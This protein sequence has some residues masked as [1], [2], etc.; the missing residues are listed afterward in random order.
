MKFLSFIIFALTFFI[1]SCKKENNSVVDK[2]CETDSVTD[3]RE[4]SYHYSYNGNKISQVNTFDHG[5]PYHKITYS[6]SDSQLIEKAYFFIPSQQTTRKYSY[7]YENG[8]LSSI[9]EYKL[10]N[11]TSIF[12]KK[13]VS[14]FIYN[15]KSLSV[16]RTLFF[17]TDTINAN[18][19]IE[20]YFFGS[21]NTDSAVLNDLSNVS[22][23]YGMD[24]KNNPLKKDYFFL[25]DPAIEYNGLIFDPVYF[26][27]LLNDKFTFSYIS[28]VLGLS[29]Q[30]RVDVNSSGKPLFFF[31]KAGL[32][33]QVWDYYSQC[34]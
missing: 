15:L 19:K 34:N 22:F 26:P 33:F 4:V 11:T 6:Y 7:K 13:R 25:S 8:L 18:Y 20:Y 28:D 32:D 9:T 30:L 17:D 10:N 2:F 14:Q 24:N 1:V 16:G 29:G 12:A 31:L 5:T 23:K 27:F 21:P 3:I